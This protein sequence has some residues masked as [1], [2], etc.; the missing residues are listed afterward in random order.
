MQKMILKNIF[1]SFINNAVFRKTIENIEIIIVTTAKR[2]KLVSQPNCQITKFVSENLLW[3][4][5]S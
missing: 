3:I 2:T 1:S 4:E 5:Y